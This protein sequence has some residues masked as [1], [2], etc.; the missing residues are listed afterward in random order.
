MNTRT[1]STVAGASLVCG[2]AVLVLGFV[3][4]QSLYPGYSTATQTISALG[5]ASAPPASQ[6]VFNAT[7]VVAGAVLLAAAYGVHAVYARSWLSGLF[8]VTS[9]GIAAVGVFPAHTGLPHFAAAVVAFGGVGVL[10]LSVAAVA[11]GAFASVSAVLGVLE[12]LSFA[13]FV[14]LGGATFLGVGGIERFVAYLAVV[15]ATAFG[16]FLLGPAPVRA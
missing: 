1:G 9:L 2:A 15:W 11:D 13:G 7:M 5:T 10:A 3:T 16:G 4:A 6:A 12:L 14:A 8:A